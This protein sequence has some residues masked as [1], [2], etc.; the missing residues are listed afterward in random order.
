[1]FDLHFKIFDTYLHLQALANKDRRE[2]KE[3]IFKAALGEDIDNDN[4]E[5]RSEKKLTKIGARIL[6]DYTIKTSK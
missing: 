2:E 3:Q 5:E 4:N 1:M 6:A